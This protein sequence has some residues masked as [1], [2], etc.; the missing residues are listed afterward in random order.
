[1]LEKIFGKWFLDQEQKEIDHIEDN[2]QK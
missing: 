1:M 2:I